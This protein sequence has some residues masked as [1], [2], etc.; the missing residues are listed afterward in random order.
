MT[1]TI[2]GRQPETAVEEITRWMKHK[3]TESKAKGFTIGISGGLDSAVVLGLATKVMKQINAYFLPCC[4]NYNDI[5]DVTLVAD[6][7]GVNVSTLE[8]DAAFDSFMSM[9]KLD[10]CNDVNL[11]AE[12]N[13]K[14]R[15]RMVTLYT[16]AN[17]NNHLVLG[18][19]NRSEATVGYTTKYGDSACDISPIAHL[20]KNQVKLVAGIIG[21]PDKIIKKAP[22][23]GLWYNQTDEEE[24]GFTYE[25]L[26]NYIL[27]GTSCDKIIDERIMK[28]SKKNMHKN[29]L[30]PMLH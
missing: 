23:A 28:L 4:L 14:A 27:N 11:L 26:D 6:A 13:L 29:L 9:F 19:G 30:P 12:G 10:Q 24:M 20:T 21:V 25:Q 16:D 17:I 15:L 2:L 22:S 7:F 18:T 8:L 5:E 3:L 1:Q